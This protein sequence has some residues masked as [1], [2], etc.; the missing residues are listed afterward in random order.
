MKTRKEKSEAKARHHLRNITADEEGL[1]HSNKPAA[2]K[3]SREE[4]KA[5]RAKYE[6]KRREFEAT[7]NIIKYNQDKLAKCNQHS[8]PAKGTLLKSM[9]MKHDHIILTNILSDHLI[10]TGDIIVVQTQAG[11]R[12]PDVSKL[13]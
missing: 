6:E 4:G 1:P 3:L 2:M 8:C 13:L 7:P 9:K 11:T 12:G 5:F 10:A